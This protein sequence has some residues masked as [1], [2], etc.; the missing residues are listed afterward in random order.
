MI[1][2]ESMVPLKVHQFLVEQNHALEQRIIALSD[3][4][5]AQAL[6]IERLREALKRVADTKG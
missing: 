6:E 3:D 2:R 5:K 1:D 4:V